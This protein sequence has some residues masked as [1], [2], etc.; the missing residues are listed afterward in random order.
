M[1]TVDN[2]TFEVRRTISR[3]SLSTTR[4]LTNGG[5]PLD[6]Q[7]RMTE[8]IKAARSVA[9]HARVIER[10]L[11]HEARARGVSLKEIRTALGMS[12]SAFSNYLARNPL[13]EERKEQLAQELEALRLLEYAWSE[14]P[15][16]DDEPPEGFLRYGVEK[17]IQ[18]YSRFSDGLEAWV[19]Q[20]GETAASLIQAG[21][22]SLRN[23]LESLFDPRVKI[24][25]EAHSPRTSFSRPDINHEVE[26]P[27]ALYATCM[28][29][30]VSM[31]VLTGLEALKASE[32]FLETED[33]REL[34]TMANLIAKAT[35]HLGRAVQAYDRPETML[36]WES[37]VSKLRKEAPWLLPSETLTKAQLK[38]LMSRR[39]LPASDDEEV[40][41]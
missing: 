17:M 12:E 4:R 6:G 35:E 5:A 25:I 15:P 2:E 7:E 34:Q 33:P 11:V 38:S 9:A 28:V 16:D 10:E 29:F 23:C 31:A 37:L 41:D 36:M 39:G 18:A 21:Q 1:F 32:K 20:E 27:A 14:D 19:G 24:A 22:D 40:P 13:A 3:F 26:N 8:M 30:R